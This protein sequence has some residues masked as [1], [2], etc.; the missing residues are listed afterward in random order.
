MAPGAFSKKKIIACIIV[1]MKST[2][3]PGKA[4][5]EIHG[6]PMIRLL[7]DR[8]KTAETIDEIV[9]CTST[10]KEDKILIDVARESGIQSFA[11]SHEDVFSRFYSAGKA[12]D[13]DI[14]VRVTGDN[15]LTCPVNID[16]MVRQHVKL[17]AEYTRTN[18]LPLG[19]TAELM[20][21]DMIARLK[22]RIPDTKS[23]EYLMLYAFDPDHFRC[24]VLDAPPEVNRPHYSL[25]VDTPEDLSFMKNIFSKFP[26]TA[27]GPRIEDVVALLD[28]SPEYTGIPDDTAIKMP[29]ETTITFAECLQ[30]MSDRAKKA[31]ACFKNTN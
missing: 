31:K 15:V 1:R 30:M 20:S 18:G 26:P 4:M 13:A 2:R 16:Q 7:I 8:M 14:L 27:A 10:D 11:G 19:V 12:F 29:G 17:D 3:L 9:V 22:K 6:K 25:T 21:M 24:A 28:A 5:A 23:S